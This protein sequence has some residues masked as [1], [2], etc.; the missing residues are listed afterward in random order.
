MKPVDAVLTVAM[1]CLL[2]V[3]FPSVLFGVF[4]SVTQDADG[5]GGGYRFS[6]AGLLAVVVALGARELL[7]RRD[8]W[9]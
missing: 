6:L 9:F 5:I 1:V 7:R 3:G 2:V 4:L 8:A